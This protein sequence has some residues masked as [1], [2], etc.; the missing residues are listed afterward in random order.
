GP[1]AG[2][3]ARRGP[4]LRPAGTRAGGRPRRG[5]VAGIRGGARHD[6][7]ARPRPGGPPP[8]RLER[9]GGR[10]ITAGCFARPG[11]IGMMGGG[12]E[13]MEGVLT[14][15]HEDEE[16]LAKPLGPAQDTHAAPR[17]HLATASLVWGIWGLMLLGNLA[18]VLRFTSPFPISDEI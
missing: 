4:G 16:S 5:R 1:V 14:R 2:G 12:S 15:Q 11:R 18:F 10:R 7:Q 6:A 8:R 9:R 13:M 3:V 17:H